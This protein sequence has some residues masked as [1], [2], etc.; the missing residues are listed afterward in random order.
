MTAPAGETS[1]TDGGQATDT[2]GAT[3]SSTTSAT[4]TTTGSEGKT[5]TQ[6]D[7]NRIVE[8]RLAGERKSVANK[9]GDLDKLVADAGELAK[10]RDE[11]KPALER[12]TNEL[13]AEKE[14]RAKAES[15][16]DRTERIQKGVDAGLPLRLA[17]TLT[18][19]TDDELAAEIEELKPFAA[20]TTKPE[21]KKRT[22]EMKSGATGSGGT[23]TDPKERAA[24]A[25]RQLRGGN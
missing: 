21:P 10:I 22:G 17:K 1:T 12:L 2:G 5:F 4:S 20:A 8:Q 14:A 7:V 23:T 9:Y 19:T 16:A 18:G 15:R 24:E 25:L 11:E 13:N 3:T 6:D